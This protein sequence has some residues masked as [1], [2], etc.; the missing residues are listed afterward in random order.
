MENVHQIIHTIAKWKIFVLI[1]SFNEIRTKVPIVPG[2]KYF[3]FLFSQSGKMQF[4][5]LTSLN[6]GGCL[7]V[8][9]KSGGSLDK[10]VSFIGL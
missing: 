10:D 1:Q 7:D 6:E 3:A 2:L 9:W 5:A 4:K 8:W